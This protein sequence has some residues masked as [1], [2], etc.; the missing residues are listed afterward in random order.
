M[1][2]VRR[3]G[4]ETLLDIP[5]GLG[6][7]SYLLRWDVLS[8][9]LDVVGEIKCTGRPTIRC[10]PSANIT[11][12]CSGLEMVTGD[13]SE[14]NV[15]RMRLRPTLVLEDGTEESM[16]V[17]VPVTQ[18]DTTSTG[19]EMTG[20]TLPDQDH[21]LDE[22]M[23]NSFGIPAN[24]SLT[25]AMV[26]LLSEVD[27]TEYFIQ[28]GGVASDPILWPAGTSRKSILDELA[29]MKGCL[30]PGFD[31]DGRYVCQPPPDMESGGYDHMY[32]LMNSRIV[33]DTISKT[34]NL[35]VPNTHKV[36]NTGPTN[37]SI[38]ASARVDRA[39][40][41]SVENLGRPRV[42][43]WKMQG[44]EDSAAAMRIAKMKAA[45]AGA[46][47][48]EISFSTH[49]DP[50]H[51]LWNRVMFDTDVYL[52]TGWSM[53]LRVGGRMTHTITRGVSVEDA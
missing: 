38:A 13:I 18:N 53:E 11:R 4:S 5:P 14:F 43:V 16:G 17:F 30:P 7:L 45:S 8:T 3:I 23:E 19:L 33:R 15:Y 24:G 49:I 50:R 44:V 31:R 9:S 22:D 21:V 52:E 25:N 39:L 35:D 37:Q 34:K 2:P 28:P 26:R 1:T 46:G 20:L 51:D 47:Y 10:N 12:Q 48:A 32:S 36:V 40:P 29:T 41:F 42:K 27:V 6:M